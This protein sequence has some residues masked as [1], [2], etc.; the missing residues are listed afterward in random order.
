MR[1]RP[2]WAFAVTLHSPDPGAR[3]MPSTPLRL[4]TVPDTAPPYDCETHGAMCPAGRGEH[5]PADRPA[6]ELSFTGELGFTGDQ[7]RS[8]RP[9]RRLA[10]AVRSGGR[11]DPGGGALAA[12][13]RSVHHRSRA[14]AHRS[15]HAAA[16]LGPAAEDPAD[17]HVASHDSRRGDD[18][19]RQLRAT[20]ARA[21][22]TLRAPARAS[23]RAGSAA[24][25][26]PM[27]LHRPDSRLTPRPPR[28]RP[29]GLGVGAHPGVAV[30]ALELTT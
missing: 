28:R 9:G 13:D 22:R 5:S 21:R 16:G 2:P 23:G 19:C 20:V 17:P 12:A 26:G 7:T 8:G 27:A 3:N 6:S 14:G 29:V 24:P 30:A 15:A 1:T 11:R 4:V 10:A 18:R 25:P